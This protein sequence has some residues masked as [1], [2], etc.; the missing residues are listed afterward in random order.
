MD[1]LDRRTVRKAS[2]EDRL[3]EGSISPVILGG[4]HRIMGAT[5][6]AEVVLAGPTTRRRYPSKQERQ[7]IGEETL[8][9][10]ASVAVIARRHDVNANEQGRDDERLPIHRE[11]EISQQDGVEYPIDCGAIIRAALRHPPQSRA[12]LLRAIVPPPH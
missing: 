1:I 3:N 11:T 4:G 5:R 7:Q 2:G 12:T 9:T 8:R 6:N 10:G